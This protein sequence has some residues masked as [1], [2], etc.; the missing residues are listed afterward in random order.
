MNPTKHDP[1]R[2]ELWDGLARAIG[3]YGKAERARGAA[4]SIS[5]HGPE[6]ARSIRATT[7]VRGLI[8]KLREG[9]APDLP[10]CVP[11]P[12]AP[13]KWVPDDL[14][15][16]CRAGGVEIPVADWDG[17]T[18]VL[19]QILHAGPAFT[20]DDLHRTLAARDRTVSTLS[21]QVASRDAEL[22]AAREMALNHPPICATTVAK[23]AEEATP[24]E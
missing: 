21:A 24:D 17:V 13:E 22:A 11:P 4:A 16:P 18:T 15:E 7:V 20:D 19:R 3:G 12:Q 5:P 1:K 23:L 8:D 10:A 14:D 2:A 6:A 9:E